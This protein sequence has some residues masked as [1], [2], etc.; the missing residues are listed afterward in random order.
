MPNFLNA[1][2]HSEKAV[3]A[4]K[5]GFDSIVLTLPRT[6]RNKMRMKLAWPA[7]NQIDQSYLVEGEPA[8][9]ELD[10]NT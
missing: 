10:S 9:S 2:P 8:T 6:L 5:S 4:A 7:G 1:I 3:D